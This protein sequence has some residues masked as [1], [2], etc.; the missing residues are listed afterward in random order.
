MAANHVAFGEHPARQWVAGLVRN[1]EKGSMCAVFLE[2]I[3]HRLWAGK[4]GESAVVELQNNQK[5]TTKKAS[6][7]P[8]RA[9]SVDSVTHG[10]TVSL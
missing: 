6:M 1:V 5:S 2:E 3:E 8:I 9:L 7:H 4:R 10:S